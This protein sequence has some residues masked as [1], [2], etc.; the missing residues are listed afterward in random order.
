MGMDRALTYKV[1]P[2]MK[3]AALLT[4]LIFFFLFL[5]ACDSREPRP[6][7]RE[8]TPIAPGP[9]ELH[10]GALVKDTSRPKVKLRR[11]KDGTYS[12]DIAGDD[13][14]EILKADAKLRGA[15]GK[16]GKKSD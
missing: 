12:W 16:S 10:A 5:P 2:P 13:V 15:V 14:D 3:C 11:N 6:N 4:S 1:F 9:G 7:P 8:M